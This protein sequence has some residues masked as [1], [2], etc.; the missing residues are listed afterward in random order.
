MVHVFAK[1]PYE[2]ILNKFDRA[3]EWLRQCESPL[4]PTRINKY[5]KTINLL[6]NAY[7]KGTTRELLNKGKFPEIVS[8]F[9]EIREIIDIWHGLKE[10]DSEELRLRLKK[11]IKG[12]ENIAY[13]SVESSSNYPRN[14]GF[15]LY[16]AARFAVPGFNIHLNANGDLSLVYQGRPVY[17]ECKRPNQLNKLKRNINKAFSQL[18]K[19][20]RAG[21]NKAVGLIA[22]SIN[23]LINPEQK[24]LVTDT[25]QDLENSL[26]GL[27]GKFIRDHESHW[28][29]RDDKR[30]IGIIVSLQVPCEIK[31]QNLLTI[32]REFGI[33]NTTI[34]GTKSHELLMNI[35]KKFGKGIYFL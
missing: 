31:S 18:E 30:T 14:I 13:E 7:K 12:P 6:L 3:I 33:N 20:Y 27:V 35:A 25:L 15:E 17:V 5:R 28:Q 4:E 24:L 21:N 1:E 23:K 19:K 32:G 10:I 2:D 16:I 9:Y 8:S 22:L 34:S 11:L 29:K 26:G